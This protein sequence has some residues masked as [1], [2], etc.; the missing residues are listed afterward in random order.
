MTSCWHRPSLVGPPL[1]RRR[2]GMASCETD[3]AVH[4]EVHKVGK[5]VAGPFRLSQGKAYDTYMTNL[6]PDLRKAV[7]DGKLPDSPALQTVLE[8][9]QK[10]HQAMRDAT[11]TAE[12]AFQEE[13]SVAV[14][15]TRQ[16]HQTLADV[17]AVLQSF[18]EVQTVRGVM[19]GTPSPVAQEALGI[20]GQGQYRDD[21]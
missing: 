10:L 17:G 21:D 13:F 20:L 6:L 8:G 2:R 16:E 1:V 3:S 14:P 9:A 7:A 18:K 15:M 4:T 12:R 11:A 19:S 5:F